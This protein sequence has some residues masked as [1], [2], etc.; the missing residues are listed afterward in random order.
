MIKELIQYPTALSLEFAANVRH[1]DDS[2]KVLIQDIKD[3]ME[4]NELNALSA[5]QT[6][7]PLSVMVIKQ[8]DTFLTLINPV[9]ITREGNITPTESTS[10]FPGLTA[11]TKR[12]KKIKMLYEDVNASQQFLSAEGDLA[13]II[14]RKADYLLGANFRIRMTEKEKKLFD[15]KLEFGTD[16]LDFNDCPTVFKRDKILHIIK[17]GFIAAMLGLIIS[18]FVSQNTISTL[19]FFENSLMLFILL[20]IVAYFFYAQYEGKAYKQCTSCQIGNILGT[21]TILAVK[22]LLLFGANYF[23]LY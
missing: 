14:Q 5:F 20:L 1:F 16:N 7:S 19:Q 22:L 9:I 10:Y 21:T 15:N 2:L 13:V 4:A 12:Y 18:F 23:L 11:K 6:G 3:T 8:E 17:F